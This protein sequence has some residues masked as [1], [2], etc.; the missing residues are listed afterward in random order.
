MLVVS[1]YRSFFMATSMEQEKKEAVFMR[2]EDAP[3]T[4][5]R[6]QNVALADA[7]EKQK[8]SL[9]TRRMFMVR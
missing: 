7:S 4:V 9:F 3:T 8:P 1:V 5:K 6:V 2:N